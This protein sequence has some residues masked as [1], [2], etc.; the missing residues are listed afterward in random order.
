MHIGYIM[1]SQNQPQRNE[2][3]IS[4]NELIAQRRTKLDALQQKAKQAGKSAYPN[5]FK[6]KNYCGD[7]QAQFDGVDK[8][9]IES[10]DKVHAKVAGRVML[11]R[12]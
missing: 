8:A 7:L 5:T 12:G 1:S 6:P 2:A 4:E 10:G 11:N 3:A 9:T